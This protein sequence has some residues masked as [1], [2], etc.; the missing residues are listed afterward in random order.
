MPTTCQVQ[1][2]VLRIWCEKDKVSSLMDHT[3]LWGKSDN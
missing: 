1:F 2:Q 3:V